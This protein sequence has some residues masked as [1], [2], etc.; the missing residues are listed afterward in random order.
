MRHTRL[1]LT[2]IQACLAWALIGCASQPDELSIPRSYTGSLAGNV[3]GGQ[4]PVSGAH[5][6]IMQGSTNGYGQPAVNIGA[7]AVARARGGGTDT[8]GPYFITDTGGSFS[9]S[10]GYTCSQNSLIYLLVLGGNPGLEQGKNNSALALAA[11]LGSCPALN[12]F[13]YSM[14]LI[15]INELTTVAAVYSLSGFM[16]SPIQISSSTSTNAVNGFTNAFSNSTQL[17][18]IVTGTALSA[19]RNKAG[20]VPDAKLRTIANIIAPCINSDGAGEACQKLFGAT[21]L[22]GVAAPTETISALLNIVHNP[23]NN[24]TALFSLA[25]PNAP[26]QPGLTNVPED[27]SISLAFSTGGASP[28]NPAID[29]SG[30][31]WLPDTLSSTLTVLDSLGNQ[32]AK[33]F[34]L[35]GRFA[36][37]TIY[38]TPPAVAIDSSGFGWLN[39]S[40]TGII[41]SYSPSYGAGVAD[42]GG[43]KHGDATFAIAL[44]DN[45]NVFVSDPTAQLVAAFDNNGQVLSGSSGFAVG[46]A[47]SGIAVDTFGNFFVADPHGNRVVGFTLSGSP[48]LFAN[49]APAVL[50]G[51]GLYQPLSLAFDSSGNLWVINAN[52]TLSEFQSSTGYIVHAAAISG[53]G[54]SSNPAAQ[55]WIPLALD[56]DG[57]P[58]VANYAGQSIS[59]FS[60]TG[61]A[62]SPAVIGI[63]TG[64]CAPRGLAIDASGD[65]WVTCES[66]TQPVLEFIG[67]AIP[68]RTPLSPA[69]AGQ[70]P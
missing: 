3:H 65:V 62:L 16:S 30:S 9:I 32:I 28:G 60:S 11:I 14:P 37:E 10:N 39:S 63:P 67:A 34:P 22:S 44:D 1:F 54:L 35:G 58:W 52:N 47:W 42:G 61:V 50:I 57:A 5:I 19:T 31:V 43:M 25:T 46:S 4:Q 59:H 64:N 26:F 48:A 33:E 66:S 70:R 45:G 12:T 36:N 49:G 8:F 15:Q 51:G 23:N 29:A 17:V 21:T 68:V 55:P 6:Y 53:G 24:V 27:W 56:G 13:Q 7:P 38:I 40:T 20:L 18:D 41:E 69:F 2:I